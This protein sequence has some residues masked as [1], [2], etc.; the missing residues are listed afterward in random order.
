MLASSQ[1]MSIESYCMTQFQIRALRLAGGWR[2]VM[3][4]LLPLIARNETLE[5][6]II[7]IHGSVGL[8]VILQ[9]TLTVSDIGCREQ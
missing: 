2:K 4:V 3:E 1:L 5:V 7:H 6:L 8:G 9:L